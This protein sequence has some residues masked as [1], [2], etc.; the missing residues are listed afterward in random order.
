MLFSPYIDL[1]AQEQIDSYLK[2]QKLNSYMKLTK[3]L[4]AL[5]DGGVGYLEDEDD[6]IHIGIDYAVDGKDYTI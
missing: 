5:A 6:H 3:A 2:L 1:M 4:R